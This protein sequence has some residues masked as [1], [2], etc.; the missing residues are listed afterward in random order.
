[1]T[2]TYNKKFPVSK[3]SLEG[4]EAMYVNEAVRTNWISSKGP[5]VERFEK[6]WADKNKMEHGVACSSGTTALVLALKAC[7]IKKGD[8]VIVPEFTMVATAWAVTYV[9]ATPI[10]VDCDDTLNMDP[11]KIKFKSKT[12]A[13]IPVSVYGRKYSDEVIKKVKQWNKN[14]KKVWIIEDLA[15]AHGTEIRGDIACYS[16]FANKIITSGEGGICLTN[17]KKK[18]ELMRWYGAMCFND[19][20]TFLHPSLGYNFRMTALQAAVALAQVERFDE[21]I[22]KRKKIEKWYNKYLP[23]EVLMPK[24]DVLWM[25]DI[26]VGDQQKRIV[27][28]LKK[29]GIETRVF[30][31]PMSQQPMYN[32][33][34]LYSKAFKW[35]YKGI[36][37]PTY[38]DMT[39][40]DVIHI[41]KTLT[42][43]L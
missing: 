35:A 5:F 36:Y 29:K 12:K 1:M 3:P 28:A 27:K 14:N 13:I 40:E 7:G 37:L 24:R 11:E 10:F 4:N 33:F 34:Y 41:S 31:K 9:G 20:H 21:I 32:R 39:E 15:E 8:E 26:N 17:D 30:F 2:L 19:D 25:Y 16:L 43:L 23:K 42:E 6:A 22:K 38:T 18:A